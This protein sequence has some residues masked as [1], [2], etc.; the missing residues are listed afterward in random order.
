MNGEKQIFERYMSLEKL[1]KILE[2]GKME[3]SDPSY[4]SD[5]NDL[6]VVDAY[7]RKQQAKYVRILCFTQQDESTLMWS[8]YAS[9]KTGCRVRFIARNFKKAIKTIPN[10]TYNKVKYQPYKPELT[11]DDID[12]LPFIKRT[13][14]KAEQEYRIVWYGNSLNNLPVIPATDIIWGIWLSPSLSREEAKGEKEKLRH[15]KKMY[16]SIQQI[17]KSTVLHE[18]RFIKPFR[19][20]KF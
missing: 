2:S 20:C 4:W 8:T 17:N 5:E 1:Y 19:E 16:P 15:F 3:F 9:S 13:P 6:A 7:R 10:I 12:N 14:Y 11:E 18:K